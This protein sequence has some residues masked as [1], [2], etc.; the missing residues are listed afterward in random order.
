MLLD[1]KLILFTA[2]SII[3]R[4]KALNSINRI[5]SKFSA[6]DQLISISLRER[7]LVPYPSPGVDSIVLS[8]G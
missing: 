7:P 3:S 6:D 8:R 2:T 5:L 1:I 4:K